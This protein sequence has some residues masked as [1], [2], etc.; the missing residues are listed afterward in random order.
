MIDTQILDK[1]EFQKILQLIARYSVTE[2]GKFK[3]TELKPLPNI[4]LVKIDGNCV[5]QAKEI[6]IS[7][8]S[9]PFEFIPD[10][11][12]ALSQSRIEGT[13]LDSKKILE[14]LRLATISRNIYQFVKNH[15]DIAADLYKLANSLF[16]DKV[17]EHHITKIIND[18]G[19]VKDNASAKLAEIKKEINSKRDELIKSVNRLIKTLSENDIVRE[20]YL[21]LRDGRIVVPVKAEHKRHIKGFI[22][23]ESS[24]GQTVYIE[25]EETLDLNNDII[26]LSF[27]EKR[28][29]ERL[30]RDL[31]KL[32]GKESSNL[33]IA[34][35]TVAE[36]DSIFAR[37]K[38][39]IEVIGSFPQ[40]END[41]PFIISQGKHPLLLKRLGRDET[42]PLNITIN[43]QKIIIITGPNA[44]G[45]TV[46]LKTIGTLALMVLSGIH[47]P[48]DPDSNFH[49]FDN[50][51]VDIGDEQSLEDD[52]STFSSHLS[53][54]KE[55]LKKATLNS[56]VLLDEIG[57][58]TDPSEGSALAS[59]VLL[60]LK[61]KGSIVLAS[62]HH[63]SLKLFAND[64]PGFQNAA[65]EFDTRNLR[66]TYVF[67]QG[68]P[69]SSYAFEIARRI[70]FDDNFL[71]V[72][73]EH[74]DAGKH[75][76]EKFL[77]DIESKSRELEEKLKSS[78]IENTRLSGLSNLY[79]KNIEQ[80]NSEK[81]D[82][83]K[84]AKTEAENY[85]KG[86]NKKIEEVIKS[87]K[88]SNARKDIIKSSQ[89]IVKDLKE[90]NKELF[91][92][93]V[94]IQGEKFDFI[95][96]DFV[97]VRNTKT[98]GKILQISQD[99]KKATVLSG[100]LKMKI[101][102]D[103]L[104]PAKKEQKVETNY[105][106]YSYDTTNQQVR[107]DIRGER[108]EQAEFEVVKFLDGAYSS[109]LNRVEI[110]HGKG[111]GALKEMV[112]RIL[113]NYDKINSFH[114]AP[115]E[116]GGDGITI[117]EFK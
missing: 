73:G 38:Y 42:V 56:L 23:S 11:D 108:A 29:I 32:I 49:F 94:D 67:R 12:T 99:K 106:S 103:E 41:K 114:F 17:F 14:I 107:I 78:E 27:A 51:L 37:A 44:G 69:G 89:Q 33:K 96:G 47:I 80:L 20:D 110:L 31:T 90:R 34:L 21:T 88:E 74:L 22:H 116:S 54:I 57:T 13:V 24:T 111:T 58:G 19:E 98:T 28:E 61:E 46:V 101:N 16:V 104:I 6:L 50:I 95:P 40:I 53:N 10:L 81:K 59:A 4:D 70:G 48:V 93:I 55:I 68:I 102:V 82:I 62:T 26:S 84:K 3:V 9:P 8:N 92:E 5:N 35:D 72:A 105:A 66:P 30:L 85:L 112:Q 79:K 77:V 7:Q 91:T 97:A 36:F 75:N 18:N 52:L 64:I 1:L 60:L 45:K 63:G 15:A 117:A 39:S 113:K 76:V 87:L 109:G 115:L 43:D 65:M 25:P 83:L 2:K 71:K 86:V 100:N